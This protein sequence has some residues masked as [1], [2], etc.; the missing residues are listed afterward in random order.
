MRYR[1]TIWGLL[2]FFFFLLQNGLAQKKMFDQIKD[3]G[4]YIWGFGQSED[5]DKANKLAL[6]DLIGKIS[7]HVESNFKNSVEATNTNL[8]EYTQSIIKTYSSVSLTNARQLVYQKRKVFY[9][10]RYIKAEELGQIFNRCAQK[11]RDYLLMG[12]RAQRAYRVGDALR[13]YYWAYALWLSHPY[14]DTIKVGVDGKQVLAGI[15]LSDR[16]NAL[17]N[18][19][20]FRVED[21][22]RNPKDDNTRIILVCT[23]NGHKVANLDYTYFTGQGKSVP[24]EVIDG[25]TEV[26]LF[27]AEQQDMEKLVLHIEYKYLRKSYQDRSLSAVLQTVQVPFFKKSVKVIP[28]SGEKTREVKDNKL[29]QPHFQSVN[30]LNTKENYFRKTVKN[31][32]VDVSKGD[33]AKAEKYF[34]PGGKQMLRKL[35]EYG[36]AS[37]LP[38][39]DTLKIIRLR[40]ETMV[41]FVPVSF[42]FPGTNRRFME[43]VV[44]TFD[45]TRKI[46]AIS[47]AISNKT[48]HDILR[49]SNNFGSLSDKYILIRFM[50]YYKTAYSLKRLSY[51]ASIFSDNALIIVGTVLKP[52]KA[53]NEMY[54][55]IGQKAVRYQRYTKTEYIRRLETVFRSKE[56]INIDFE[57]ATVKKVNGKEKIYGI[58]I[59][60]HY[61]SSDYDD[62]GYLFLMIDLNDSLKPTIYVRTW[63]PEKNP[64][65]SIYGLN[66]FKIN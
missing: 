10:L 33:Y 38:L 9:V 13:Y 50:E 14:R 24:Q 48:I 5:Y 42:S 35:M 12:T 19:I 65:G 17:L 34:T 59:A 49:H 56:Y 36:R 44:F 28:L 31:V 18:G 15:L 55:S 21:K 7:V 52:A 41:R 53:I 16:I 51:I 60:Q 47:F 11:I 30:R 63:Q 4:D 20:H 37:V 62:F 25:E 57:D 22:L 58:Q 45:S 32:L 61:Y 6:D 23:Y 8:K 54:S 66:D 29:I 64:D 40:G 2:V 39:H 3:S 1:F 27:G 46:E 43:N 26:Y